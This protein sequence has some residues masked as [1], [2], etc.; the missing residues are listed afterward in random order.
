MPRILFCLLC[1]SFFSRQ[2]AHAQGD[3]SASA[4]LHS[5]AAASNR[6]QPVSPEKEA[7]IRHFM[8]LTGKETV[9]RDI[10]DQMSK[11]MRPMVESSLPPGEYRAKLVDLLVE[12]FGTRF[13][14]E[15]AMPTVEAVYARRFSDED[16]K[17]LIAFYESP[18]GKKES[19]VLSDIDAETQKM[20]GPTEELLQECMEQVLAE[21]PDLKEAMEKASQ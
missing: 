20:Q 12:K 6:V 16:L 4:S 1:F 7:A 18:L 21:H 17:Q 13:T 9:S 3:S 5:K 15:I 2:I 8:Q 19:G 14:A 11:L 10:A